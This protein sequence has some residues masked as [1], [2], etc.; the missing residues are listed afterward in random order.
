[1]GWKFWKRKKEVEDTTTV[2]VTRGMHGQKQIYV[3]ASTSNKALDL[4][5]KLEKEIR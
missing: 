5:Q 2:I 3:Q 1:M 4:Y